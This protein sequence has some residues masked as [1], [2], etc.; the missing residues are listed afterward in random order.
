MEKVYKVANRSMDQE[1]YD[2]FVSLS[3]KEQVNMVYEGMSPK[4]IEA[5]EEAL[6]D[7]P[8]GDITSRN[9]SK[10]GKASAA[11]GDN[12]GKGDTSKPGAD[13]S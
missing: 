7:V 6:K 4:N 3:K 8:N 9:D 10:S 11:V 2:K 12:G 5:A 13:K 1:Q